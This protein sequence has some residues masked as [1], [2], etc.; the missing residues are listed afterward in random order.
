MGS[1]VPFH[2][3]L[4][5]AEFNW[6]RKEV[7]ERHLQMKLIPVSCWNYIVS[8]SE[9]EVT[10][11][12]R[13]HSLHQNPSPRPEAIPVFVVLEAV[14]VT[15][16]SGIIFFNSECGGDFNRLRLDFRRIRG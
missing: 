15:A 11:I 10:I 9:P 12:D 6:A 7:D 13:T 8:L 16:V 4:D 14:E 2:S 1:G 3:K 5:V